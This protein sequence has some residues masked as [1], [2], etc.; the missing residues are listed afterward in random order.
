M[1]GPI[2]WR[3]G[4]R[5]FY[6]FWFAIA[7]SATWAY[8]LPV[9]LVRS[10]HLL[11]LLHSLIQPSSPSHDFWLAAFRTV[12]SA[13]L[14][15]LLAL[16]GSNMLATAVLRKNLAGVAQVAGAFLLIPFFLGSATDAFLIKLLA[17]NFGTDVAYFSERG[18]GLVFVSLLLI[19]LWRI[20]TVAA[21]TLVLI[22][23]DAP[24]N[25]LTYARSLR[26][27]FREWF[28]D[29]VWPLTR[30]A[31]ILLSIFVFIAAEHEYL[32]TFLALKPSPGTGTELLS[33]WMN[34][35]YTSGVVGSDVANA[36]DTV[37]AAG[38]IFVFISLAVAAITTIAL[39][40]LVQISTSSGGGRNP[41]G[42]KSVATFGPPASRSVLGLAAVALLLAI[43]ALMPIGSAVRFLVPTFPAGSGALLGSTVPLVVFAAIL[44]TLVSMVTAFI[45]RLMISVTVIKTRTVILVMTILLSPL[46]VPP[47]L[48]ALSSFDWWSHTGGGVWGLRALWLLAQIVLVLP[49]VSAFLFAVFLGVSNEELQYQRSIRATTP[50]VFLNSF[51]G[52]FAG[53]ALFG[54]IFA[55]LQIWNEDAAS[56]VFDN[57]VPSF[58]SLISRT[59]SGRAESI[60]AASGYALVGIAVAVAL[61]AIWLSIVASG[62]RG[63]RA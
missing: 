62:K 23:A 17:V 20:G 33:H 31:S 41:G 9:V 55:G 34:R 2:P 18:G 38:A 28:R 26:L 22:V 54:M 19:L 50:E 36:Q 42:G 59:L 45:A 27:R 35:I 46:A 49:V 13:A 12:A 32:P 24:E 3:A 4:I 63:A 11:E 60:S 25:V 61:I 30:P 57:V 21:Y 47:F 51:A 39:I 58:A 16:Y 40:A 14:A 1:S 53:Q 7:V 5:P 6:L 44:A 43:F 10:P 48:I 56:P 29:I 37:K 15:A 52:R 8:A